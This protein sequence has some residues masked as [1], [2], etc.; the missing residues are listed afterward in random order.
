MGYE[1][2]QVFA[3][4]VGESHMYASTSTSKEST[5]TELVANFVA[6]YEDSDL[7]TYRS[8]RQHKHFRDFEYMLDIK[9]CQKLKVDFIRY[10]KQLEEVGVALPIHD[11]DLE[12]MA[13]DLE[14]IA[15]DEILTE[16]ETDEHGESDFSDG[17]N[18]FY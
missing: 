18:S 9:D 17:D 1:L 7:V 13:E 10:T 16:S 5:Q 14:E 12:E 2:D 3:H 11:D 15:E 4:T 8:N 6:A